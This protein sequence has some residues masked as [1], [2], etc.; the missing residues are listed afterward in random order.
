MKGQSTRSPALETDG[1]GFAA[2][3]AVSAQKD[4]AHC[5]IENV[6]EEVLP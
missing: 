4:W 5:L 6:T 1:F 3:I 2:S